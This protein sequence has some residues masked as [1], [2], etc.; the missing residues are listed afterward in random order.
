MDPPSEKQIAQFQE[1]LFTG[2]LNPIASPNPLLLNDYGA[3][4]LPSGLLSPTG[5]R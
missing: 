1:A 3:L 5:I 2:W 4:A